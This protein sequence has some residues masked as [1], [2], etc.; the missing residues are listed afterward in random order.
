M[1]ADE[2][3]HADGKN[4]PETANHAKYANGEIGRGMIGKGMGPEKKAKMEV[5]VRA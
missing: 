4:D 3:R 5:E 1:T 2:R